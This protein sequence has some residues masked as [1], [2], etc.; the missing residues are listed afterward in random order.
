M[1]V[2]SRRPNI[3]F[4][5]WVRTKN[6][7]FLL[8]NKLRRPIYRIKLINALT[9]IENGIR[10]GEHFK[11]W[12]VN[13]KYH[14]GPSEDGKVRPAV[15]SYLEDGSK[16]KEWWIHGRIHR[17]KVNGVHLPAK[18]YYEGNK[19][20]EEWY[21]WGMRHRAKVN[22]IQLPAIVDNGTRHSPQ[23][24]NVWY[25]HDLLHRVDGPASIIG[26]LDYP[27][28]YIWKFKGRFHHP[29]SNPDAMENP[30]VVTTFINLDTKQWW[31][32]G[33]LQLAT[34]GDII[35]MV[36]GVD[37]I[38]INNLNGISKNI[39]KKYIHLLKQAMYNM[40]ELKDQQDLAAKK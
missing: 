39:V 12:T 27:T 11:I 4:L 33:N 23:K 10:D 8:N 2:L 32:D 40:S 6:S 37:I 19:T 20:R 15:I 22:R 28:H 13:G 3:L 16:T 18:I 1:D 29:D 25:W 5:V 14:R 34:I 30:A 17:D 35:F 26:D 36:K 9:T 24:T 7:H 21:W 38:S 31:Y